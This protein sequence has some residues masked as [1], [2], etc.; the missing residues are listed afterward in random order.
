MTAKIKKMI[1]AMIDEKQ[2][3]GYVSS[4]MN[5][6]EREEYNY[7]AIVSKLMNEVK[8]IEKQR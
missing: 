4:K 3:K 1:I 5:E 2:T 6:E 7:K 8:N